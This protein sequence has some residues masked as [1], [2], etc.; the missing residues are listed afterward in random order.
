M[1]Q[2][3][4]SPDAATSGARTLDDEFTERLTAHIVEHVSLDRKATIEPETNLLLTGLVDS[5]GVMLIIDW[6]E[7]DLGISI[8]PGDVVLE[9][10]LTVQAMVDFART[11]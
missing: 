3:H 7:G 9:N 4:A 5:L 8:H 1:T 11:Q 2:Q 10:F 6:I